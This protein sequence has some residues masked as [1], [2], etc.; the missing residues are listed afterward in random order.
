VYAYAAED[1]ANIVSGPAEDHRGAPGN[2]V[3]YRYP[4]RVSWGNTA[5]DGFRFHLVFDYGDHDA[6]DP[7]LDPASLWPARPDAFSWFR[8]GFDVRCHR[9]C[10]RVLLFHD[11]ASIRPVPAVVRSL[12]LTYEERPTVTTLTSGQTVGWRWDG[13]RYHKATSPPISMTYTQPTIDPS[14]RL[15]DGIEDLPNG[16]DPRVWRF[17]DL[18]GEGRNVSIV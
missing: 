2:G 15:V 13:A 10:R 8:A 1:R 17:V 12:E 4:K 6:L 3:A 14:V 7:G 18:D 9:L 11:F 16:F 5:A